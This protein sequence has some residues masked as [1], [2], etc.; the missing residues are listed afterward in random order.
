MNVVAVVR[1][2]LVIQRRNSTLCYVVR[3]RTGRIEHM[4][5]DLGGPLA[6]LL[7]RDYE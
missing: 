3:G 2:A 1:F 6:V 4:L 7:H 5:S